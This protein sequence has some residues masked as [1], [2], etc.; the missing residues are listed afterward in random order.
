MFCKRCSAPMKH[1]YRF[2]NNGSFEY[3]R[4]PICNSE[5][6]P[7]PLNFNSTHVHPREGEANVLR[8]HNNNQRNPQAF[9]R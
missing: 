3:Y 7:V 2:N 9:K 6:K 5:S 4:C 8:L 1:G